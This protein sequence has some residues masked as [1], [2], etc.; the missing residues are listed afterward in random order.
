MAL[1]KIPSSPDEGGIAV[2][3]VMSLVLSW[4]NQL[5]VI[6]KEEDSIDLEQYP[7]LCNMALQLFGEGAATQEDIEKAKAVNPAKFEFD[8]ALIDEGQDWPK[9]E[10]ERHC[11]GK[12]A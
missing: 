9:E 3:T 2:E 8:Y 12:T 6:G 1:M 4:L 5:G 7:A 11:Q 10:A